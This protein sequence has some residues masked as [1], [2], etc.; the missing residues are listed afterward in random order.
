M[1]RRDV[2][3]GLGALSVAAVAPA[4]AAAATPSPLTG[5]VRTNWSK[6]PLSFG[7]YSFLA[8]GSGDADRATLAAPLEDKLFFAGEALNPKYQSSVHAAYES[9]LRVA[10]DLARA[11]HQRIAIV[12]A[13]MSGLTAA[14]HLAGEGRDVTVLEARERIG[15]R[16]WT[17][18]SLGVAVDLGATWIHG[19][20]GNPITALADRAG[21]ERAP[22]GD[23]V[24]VRGGDGR[25]IWQLFMPSWLAE[26]TSEIS[27]GAEAEEM[28]L[29]EA[30]A[31]YEAYGIGY[32]GG[33]VKFPNGYDQVL[34]ALAG[35]YAVQRGQVVTRLSYGAFGVDL[36]TSGG[37][38]ERYDAAIVTV[39][40]GVLKRGA[41]AFDPALPTDKRAAIARMGMGTLDKLYLRFEE[42][43]W[44]RDA[45]V[46][47]TP[48][49]DLPRGQFNYWVNF[50]KYLGAPILLAFNYASQARALSAASDAEMVDKALATLGR[51]YPS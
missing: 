34:S 31:A 5:Y 24:V 28:N 20:V 11:P 10:Q 26:V 12:G 19:P 32:E 49:N 39:P 37:A 48:E 2:L 36:E 42:P 51:A 44:D 17:D 40:L 21:L 14:H 1:D 15:G 16:I 50:E 29:V 30:Q 43:F 47:L 38:S 22:T 25:K 41:I 3:G 18:R 33:D 4:F 7:S 35:D 23:E 9:G 8:A 45:T 46:I 27:V 13:G 6:D